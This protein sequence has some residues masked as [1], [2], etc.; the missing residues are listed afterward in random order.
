MRGTSKPLDKQRGNEPVTGFAGELKIKF[1][2]F[3]LTHNN[4]TLRQNA[5]LEEEEE[6]FFEDFKLHDYFFNLLGSSGFFTYRQV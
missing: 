4:R 2:A 1:L 6:V 3:G 5:I